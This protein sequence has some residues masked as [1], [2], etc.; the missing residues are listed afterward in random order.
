MV[1]FHVCV[2]L[3][4]N[5]RGGRCESITAAF[6]A[7]HFGFFFRD[8]PEQRGTQTHHNT[9]A[10]HTLH[11]SVSH[12]GLRGGACGHF[13]S[14]PSGF[15]SSC[16]RSA[17]SQTS[18]QLRRAWPRPCAL[19]SRSGRPRTGCSDQQTRTAAKTSQQRQMTHAD[20]L[21][22]CGG[23]SS[24]GLWVV[25]L[26]GEALWVLDLKIFTSCYATLMVHT[27]SQI[28]TWSLATQ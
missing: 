19:T 18:A 16:C 15:R 20:T 10:N 3:R 8:F 25:V 12:W 7:Q 13:P 1:V 11:L 26:R 9:S 5:N 24:Q 23:C 22:P 27:G 4:C 14:S 21:S 28:S 6:C 17:R 2:G